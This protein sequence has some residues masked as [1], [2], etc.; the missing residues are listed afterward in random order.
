M[1][2]A[3]V[4]PELII[5]ALA[6]NLV[7][8][9][10]HHGSIFSNLR[11]WAEVRGGKLGELISCPYCLSHWAGFVVVILWFLGFYFLPARL[12]V[13]SFAATRTANLINDLMKRYVRNQKR[14]D[15]NSI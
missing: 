8:E 14:N 1:D 11:L 9:T 7:V 5:L 13:M 10:I 6:T 12:V 2:W 15:T 3:G 4:L